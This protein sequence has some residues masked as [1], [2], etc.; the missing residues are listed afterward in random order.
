MKNFLI[1]M[2]I[3]TATLTFAQVDSK[4]Q[5]EPVKQAVES[6]DIKKEMNEQP[7]KDVKEPDEELEKL[8]DAIEDQLD[9]LEEKTEELEL[10][11][12][13]MEMKEEKKVEEME[14]SD[15]KE[16]LKIKPESDLKPTIDE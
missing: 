14:D 1:L 11:E 7:V 5:L 6:I 10:L 15:S 9:Q 3:F 8:G 12:E 13:E 16:K 2:L 4:K